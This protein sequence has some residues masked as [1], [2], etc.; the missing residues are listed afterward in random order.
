MW[1]QFFS[2]NA[3]FAIHLFATLVCLAVSWL[4]LDSWLARRS[5]IG[6][7]RW[8]GFALLGL[9]FLAQATL[10]EQTV[11]GISN[12]GK[13]ASGLTL[14]FRVIAYICIIIGQI[15]DPL[16]AVPDNKGLILEDEIIPDKDDSNEKSSKSPKNTNML[17]GIV[18][19]SSKWAVVLGG[20][21]TAGLYW[22]RATTG[23]ERH[24]K[25]VAW[26]FL[27][28][29]LAD[30]IRLANLLRDTTNPIL[31][32]WVS[33]FGW[34][35]WTEQIVLLVGILL[36][37]KWV[38]SYLTERFFSQLFMIFMSSI[39][40]IFLIVSVVLTGLLLRNIRRDMIDN[41][42]TAVHVLDFA[43]V[44]K[45]AESTAGVELLAGNKDIVEAINNKNHDKLVDLTQNYLVNKKQSFL[46]IVNADGQVLLRGQE[47]N[48]WG[49][50]L[51]S[52]ILINRALLG[53]NKSS[54]VVSEG[55]GSP[56]VEVRSATAVRNNQGNIIG[57][58]VSGVSLDTA[59]VDGVKNSTGL[60]SSVY[61]GNV[62]ASTT[63]LSA[64]GKSR[65]TGVAVSQKI[66]KKQVIDYGNDYSGDLTIQNRQLLGAVLPL[67]DVDNVPVGMLMVAKPQSAV[68]RSAGESVS[69]TFVLTAILLIL[70]II[71]AFFV[72]KNLTKQLGD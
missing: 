38:W 66:V 52:D 25:A 60:H 13:I 17:F 31:F 20:F 21:A 68:L 2:Q 42:K 39:I 53:A 26:A 4:Y 48:R 61:G 22:R 49:D 65:A 71:P 41:L 58:I 15:L 56:I 46:I 62:I 32:S 44:S 35:W 33:A 37:G 18:A 57:V 14:F 9:S 11:L 5:V 70:S 30:L 7:M 47:P 55:I 28:L 45:Q 43:I 36:L 16:Q 24:L 34:V 3:H 19:V 12:V 50:S 27:F 51:S 23:L 69:L 8:L 67:K 29:G 59:F 72:T 10:I 1:L 54:V 6:L 64:D 63:L 40:A